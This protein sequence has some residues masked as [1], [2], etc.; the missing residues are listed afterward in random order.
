MTRK[1]AH[2][3]Q[4]YGPNEAF[5]SR[6]RSSSDQFQTYVNLIERLARNA[7]EILENWKRFTLASLAVISSGVS[8]VTAIPMLCD[9]AARAVMIRYGGR[10]S[11]VPLISPPVITPLR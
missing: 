7:L 1:W 6:L 4:K 8:G 9:G 3:Y 10:V 11:T 2:R 5:S